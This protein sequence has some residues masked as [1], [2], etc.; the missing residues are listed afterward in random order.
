MGVGVVGKEDIKKG[1]KY[2]VSH[3]ESPRMDLKQKTRYEE[4]G[5]AYMKTHYYG[6]IKKYQ[7]ASI[8][9]SLHGVVILANGERRDIVIG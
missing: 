5:L 1:I 2:V 3:I 8:P 9:L 7:W 4:L 6:G